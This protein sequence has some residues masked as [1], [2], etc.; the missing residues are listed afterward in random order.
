MADRVYLSPHLDDAVFSCGGV[1]YQQTSMGD[2]VL[3]VTICAG[4]PMT[5]QLSPFAQG[6]HERWGIDQ[7]SVEVR[8][9]EDLRACAR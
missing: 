3:V 8:R 6:L 1:I 7:A 9:E 5:D 2:E 4:E